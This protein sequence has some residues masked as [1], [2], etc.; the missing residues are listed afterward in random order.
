MVD[1]VV[2]KV[3]DTNVVGTS[4]VRKRGAL[5]VELMEY[6]DEQEEKEKKKKEEAEKVPWVSADD[7]LER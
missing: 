7:V 4:K 5:D 1:K 2:G 6:S 3:A